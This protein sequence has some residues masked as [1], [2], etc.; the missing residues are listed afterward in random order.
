MKGRLFII[1]MVACLLLQ[2][3]AATTPTST[4]EPTATLFSRMEITTATPVTP[5][6]T[7]TEPPTETPTETATP[8]PPTEIPSATPTLDMTITITPTEVVLE[9]PQI[10]P[11]SDT[12]CRKNPN[13]DSEAI[14][15]FL[16]GQTAQVLAKDEFSVWLLI[17]NPTVSGNPNCWVWAGNTNLTGDLK[18][19]PV[20]T[21]K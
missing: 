19:V 14:A 4:P 21:I 13:K 7:L 20:Y 11:K 15:Y 18:M 2:G 12:N 1:Q 6:A 10:S 9:K 17:P 5:T 3:C 8:L 16:T